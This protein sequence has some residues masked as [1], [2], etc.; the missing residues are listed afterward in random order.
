[1]E[2][3]KQVAHD[4]LQS[5]GL[6][7]TDIPESESDGK[8]ADLLANDDTFQYL[9]EVKQR[10]EDP[11]QRES[12]LQ[13][14]S[15]G[16][17]VPS[18]EP[19]SYSNR[20]DGILRDGLKQIDETPADDNTFN[21]LWFHAEGMDAD[22]KVRRARNTF[23]GLVPLIP[24]TPHGETVNCFYFDFCTSFRMPT[25]HGLA[26]VDGDGLQ[27]C[28]NE[29]ADKADHFR[30]SSLVQR[31]GTAVI[32]PFAIESQGDAIV[33]R[34]CISRREEQAVL[35]ELERITNTKFTAVRMNRH[36]ASATVFRG[37][38]T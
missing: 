26:L 15:E 22:L 7:V 34:S 11:E 8:R 35:D 3:A 5:L 38:A 19:H 17:V 32:D 27:L 1:M 12:N 33:L 13:R 25:V 28:I 10:F 6:V 9:I 18:S 20:I 24:L 21:L 30:R 23:Y 16:E 14:M 2:H 4:A 36:S 37:R 31:L 29:F